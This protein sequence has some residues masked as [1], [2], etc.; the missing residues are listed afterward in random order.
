MNITNRTIW[1][2]D[3]LH[4]MRGPVVNA[5]C[6]PVVLG[7]G[8][9]AL[10]QVDCARFRPVVHIRARRCLVALSTWAGATSAALRL[11]LFPTA[12]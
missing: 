12:R 9:R 5:H 4:I 11:L 1:T 7:A 3:N 2:G 8:L 6:Q 10:P